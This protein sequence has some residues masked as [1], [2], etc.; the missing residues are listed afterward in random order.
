MLSFFANVPVW[1]LP[2]FL[3][4]LAVGMRATR[5]RSVPKLLVY[6]LPFLGLLSLK[7]VLSFEA[8]IA[9][10]SIFALG[11]QLGAAFGFH[12]QASWIAGSTQNRVTIKGE[13]LTLTTIMGL[14]AV[15]FINGATKGIAPEL[16]NGALY[17]CVFSAIA[18]LLSGTFIGR[19]GRIMT[20]PTVKI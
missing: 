20:V 1:I 14:F 9:A 16:A 6:S 18:G 13:W 10:L 2:L 7:S 3:G 12:R 8:Q 19:A 5:T 4:L 15:N 17:A 11:Y